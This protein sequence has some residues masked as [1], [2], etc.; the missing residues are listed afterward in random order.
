MAPC[1]APFSLTRDMLR[2]QNA[3]SSFARSSHV[4]SHQSLPLLFFLKS[5][6]KETR[7]GHYLQPE[8]I[9]PMFFLCYWTAGTSQVH[10]NYLGSTCGTRGFCLDIEM[11]FPLSFSLTYVA[12]ATQG[13][14]HLTWSVK[15]IASLL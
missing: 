7:F 14:L 9:G 12:V 4:C 11:M 10:G 3:F 1:C 8:I 6:Q 2:G 15:F 5:S 13:S